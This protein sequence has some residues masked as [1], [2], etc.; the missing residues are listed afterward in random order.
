MDLLSIPAMLGTAS[1]LEFGATKYEDRNWEQ[2]IAMSKIYGSTLRHLMKWFAGMDK[3]EESGLYHLH[4]AGC[5][6]MF[7]Q[8]F[9]ADPDKYARFDDRP[10]S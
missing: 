10:T 3:D 6:V 2:G 1:V 7:L 8:H 9:N 4:H 5:D